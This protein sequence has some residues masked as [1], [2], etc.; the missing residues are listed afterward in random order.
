MLGFIG[1][2][3]Y[4]VGTTYELLNQVAADFLWAWIHGAVALVLVAS[5]FKAHTRLREMSLPA[6]ACNIAFAAMF[7]WAFF[8]FIWGLSTVRPVS[9]AGPGL[10]FAVAAGEQL[11]ANAWNRK[12]STKER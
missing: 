3:N 4:T 7:T 12:A 2:L 6:L 10:A 9:L 5:L 1:F 11:L 8:N